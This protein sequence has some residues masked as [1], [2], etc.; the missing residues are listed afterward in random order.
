MNKHVNKYTRK[1]LKILDCFEAHFFDNSSGQLGQIGQNEI[2]VKISSIVKKN[3]EFCEKNKYETTNT[4]LKKLHEKSE[5]P[6]IYL[7]FKSNINKL[8]LDK[9]QIDTNFDDI[10]QFYN[11]YRTN[12]QKYSVF[13][14]DLDH[15]KILTNPPELRK[16]LHKLLYDNNFV[17]LDIMQHA[18]SEDLILQ[19]YDS[20]ILNIKIYTPIS[21]EDNQNHQIGLIGADVSLINA[22]VLTLMELFQSDKKVNLVAFYGNQKKYLP[23]NGETMCS[24]NINSGATEAGKLVMVW[25]K[26]EFYKVLIHELIHYFKIDFYLGDDLYGKVNAEFKK[27]VKIEGIDRINESYTEA[28]AMMIHSIFYSQIKKMDLMTVLNNEVKFS[29]FQIA[30]ILS[31]SKTL[32]IEDVLSKKVAIQQNTSAVSYFIIKTLFMLNYDILLDHIS[33]HGFVVLSAEEQFVK[34]YKQLFLSKFNQKL[35]GA[36]LLLLKLT[37]NHTFITKT[38]RMSMHQL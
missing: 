2:I 20:K 18:E 25:R 8:Q 23:T 35:L 36:M 4:K 16:P 37:T 17:S 5:Y 30:K 15:S 32:S 27:H 38:M 22:I 13:R 10:D 14:S 29:H 3:L 1:L 33:D 7:I 28:L 31:H 11:W 9:L 19:E 12:H 6:L 24:D 34:L 21:D 26:E